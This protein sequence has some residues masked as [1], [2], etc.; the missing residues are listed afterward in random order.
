MNASLGLTCE[1]CESPLEACRCPDMDARLKVGRA[2]V[3]MKWCLT[4]DKHYRRC[5]C[6]VPN[7]TLMLGDTDLGRG[8]F[9]TAGGWRVISRTER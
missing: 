1:V 8:P 6:A 3:A 2:D 7:F 4:C 9:K 5:Q